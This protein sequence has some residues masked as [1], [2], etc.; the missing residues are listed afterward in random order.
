[1]EAWD[2]LNGCIG[3][4]P[5]YLPVRP[6]RASVGYTP[7]IFLRMSAVWLANPLILVAAVNNIPLSRYYLA[8]NGTSLKGMY[9]IS[10]IT[11]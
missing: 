2:S 9:V 6:P 10:A 5:D 3:K 4:I 7:S 8:T 11:Y 1:M